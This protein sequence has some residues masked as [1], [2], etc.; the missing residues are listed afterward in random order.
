[1]RRNG[2][3]AV[4]GVCLPSQAEQADAADSRYNRAVWRVQGREPLIG[5][6][7]GLAAL[8]V[9]AA[10]SVVVQRAVD[11]GGYPAAESSV[12]WCAAT[13]MPDWDSHRGLE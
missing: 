7:M 1:M 8:Q 5:G 3:S 6:V 4:K 13:A 9:G 11:A 2:W 10:S 12:P